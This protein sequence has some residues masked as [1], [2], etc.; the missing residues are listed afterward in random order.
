MY[1]PFS[2]QYFSETDQ[3]PADYLLYYKRATALF[4]LQR[5]SSALE[6][7]EKVLSLTFNSFDNAHLMKARIYAREG[8]F[9]LAQSSLNLYIKA[10]GK[11]SDAEE[12][13]RDIK[14]GESLKNKALKERNAELWN[15][16][17][18][19]TSQSLRVA[20]HSVEI[21]TWRAECALAAG[22]VESCVG[23]LT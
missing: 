2:K 20:T 19:T 22:D 6:D 1:H 21:R 17:V 4:S 7:F 3:S 16:C 14:Q 10:K 23:D 5:H 13:Q 15:A 8:Q 12:V 9:S 18:D 11:D